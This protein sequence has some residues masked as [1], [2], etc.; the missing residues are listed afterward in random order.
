MLYVSLYEEYNEKTPFKASITVQFHTLSFIFPIMAIN[1]QLYLRE[2]E[3]TITIQ[4]DD[5]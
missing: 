4:H 3:T 5:T 1:A 2:Y